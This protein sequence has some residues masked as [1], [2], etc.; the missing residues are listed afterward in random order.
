M[1]LEAVCSDPVIHLSRNKQVASARRGEKIGG[2]GRARVAF[3]GAYYIARSAIMIEDRRSG[4]MS[5]CLRQMMP[6]GCLKSLSYVASD[7][8]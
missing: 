5:R 1:K 7:E 6:A 2:D 4:F 8:C 3:Q